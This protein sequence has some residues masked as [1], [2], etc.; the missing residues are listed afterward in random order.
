MTI[1]EAINEID[2][3][4]PNT[5]SRDDKLKWLTRL[6]WKVKREIID[7]HE[8]GKDVVYTGYDASVPLDTQLLIPDSHGEVY[9]FWLESQIDYANGEIGKYNNSIAMYNAAYLAYANYYN[10]QHMPL[11]ATRKYF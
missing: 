2:A 10:R 11:G 4:K 9:S 7:T 6:D 1:I 3:R 8:G 5:Y